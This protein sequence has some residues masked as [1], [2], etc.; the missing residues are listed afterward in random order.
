MFQHGYFTVG[1][2]RGVPIRLHWTLPVGALIFAGLS[3]VIWLAF[4]VIVLVHEGGHALLVRRYGYQVL[5]ID[6]TG[7]GGMCRWA[8]RPTLHERGVIAWGGVLA[9]ALLLAVTVGVIA[10]VGWPTTALGA[11]LA[12][13]FTRTNAAIIVLNLLPMPPFDGA[14]AW[15]L[16]WR[17]IQRL[18]G[19]GRVDLH[20]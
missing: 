7:F 19:G 2:L 6:L 20:R 4:A 15:S 16:V 1:R 5:S 10:I 8:G 12:Y 14:E 9:Q 13:A 18:R 3:P 17:N 11:S